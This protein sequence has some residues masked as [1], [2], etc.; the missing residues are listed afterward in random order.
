MELVIF[1]LDGTLADDS[2][3][4]EWTYQYGDPTNFLQDATIQAVLEKAREFE[5]DP[6]TVVVYM[7]GRPRRLHK[8]TKTWLLAR[9]LKGWLYCRPDECQNGDD[10]SAWKVRKTI[11]LVLRSQHCAVGDFVTRVVMFENKKQTLDELKESWHPLMPELL[12][13]FVTKN[14]H[15]KIAESKDTKLSKPLEVKQPNL[16]PRDLVNF[17]LLMNRTAEE[18]WEKLLL[19]EWES[20]SQLLDAALE[21]VPG[22]NN[23]R[24]FRTMIDQLWEVL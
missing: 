15:L 17:K 2:H 22:R 24:E 3:R 21:F 13:V 9:G 16:E 5:R 14:Y 1:D 18:G 8:V 10:V 23:R 19:R 4:Q 20:R 12:C 7:T 6:D 11:Q